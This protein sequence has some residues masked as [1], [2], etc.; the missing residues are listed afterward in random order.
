MGNYTP[1]D[2]ALVQEFLTIM[3]MLHRYIFQH[4]LEECDVL[5]SPNQMHALL[6]LKLFPRS[7]MTQL[8]SRLMVSKQQL[9][10]IV[11]VLAEKGLV[12]RLGDENNRRLV[13]LELTETGAHAVDIFKHAQAEK[14]AR[15]FSD[16]SGEEHEQL[17]CALHLMERLLKEKL[18]NAAPHISAEN[19]SDLLVGNTPPKG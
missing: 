17:L 5:I 4:Q 2:M 15:F 1:E 10:K 18:G 13:L 16:I 3:P 12:R 19:L 14:A 9:T 6:T 11:D 8:A 7:N